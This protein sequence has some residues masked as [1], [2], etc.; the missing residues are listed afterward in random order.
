MAENGY[1][2]KVRRTIA[3]D[4]SVIDGMATVRARMVRRKEWRTK[5]VSWNDV[6]HEL[7]EKYGADE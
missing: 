4:I 5:L 7:L 1:K 3:V 6:I 2:Q